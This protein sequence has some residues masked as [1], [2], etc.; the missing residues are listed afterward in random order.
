MAP[1]SRTGRKTQEH[2]QLAPWVIAPCLA[3][4]LSACQG[5]DGSGDLSEAQAVHA[6]YAWADTVVLEVDIGGTAADTVLMLPTAA[7]R[8]SN[9]VIVVADPYVP[10]VR[11]FSP[12][13]ELVRSVGTKGEGPGEFEA[14]FW[15]QQCGIDSVFAWDAGQMRVSVLD[16]T[17]SVVRQ[18]RIDKS[19][20]I[21]ECSRNGVFVGDGPLS[22]VQASLRTRNPGPLRV[23]DRQGQVLR[24]LGEVPLFEFRPLGK[25]TKLALS[26]S[27]IF[28]GTADSAWVDVLDFNGRRVGGVTI[29]AAPRKPTGREYDLA[30]EYQASAFRTQGER[31]QSKVMLRRWFP[32]P[33][34]VVPPYTQLFVDPDETLWAVTSFPWDSVTVLQAVTSTG[35]QLGEV[36]LPRSIKVFEVGDGYVLGTY[37]T[38]DG[39]PHVALYRIPALT[40]GT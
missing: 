15:L 23:W 20:A 18:Y 1:S 3:Y 17:G 31:D 12:D 11:Y 16:G 25:A 36:R 21:F 29:G 27:L 28:V 34:D 24:T 4:C 30:I 10:A 40:E 32:E 38:E 22:G 2:G 39:V 9:G 14:P 37:E 19:P 6:A 26:D 8:L 13:G 7:T 5:A 35:K 33:P